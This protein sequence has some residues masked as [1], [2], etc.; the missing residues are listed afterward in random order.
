[1]LQEGCRTIVINKQPYCLSQRL[2]E[3]A[4]AGARKFRADFIFRPYTAEDVLGLWK[5]IRAGK[6]IP[7]SHEGNYC[8]GI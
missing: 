6:S 5:T 7:G 4:A 2:G 1:M 8:R 3:L